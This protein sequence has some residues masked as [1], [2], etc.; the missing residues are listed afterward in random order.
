MANARA[1]AIG[2]NL[3]ALIIAELFDGPHRRDKV[4]LLASLN[5]DNPN[6]D[7]ERNEI[8]RALKSAYPVEG[9]NGN[10][11]IP[12]LRITFQELAN[13]QEGEFHQGIL[14]G[15]LQINLGNAK[16]R[17]ISRSR[18]IIIDTLIRV[19]PTNAFIVADDI[20]S[21]LA[22]L[23]AFNVLNPN[24]PDQRNAILAALKNAFPDEPAIQAMN[25][26]DFQHADINGRVEDAKRVAATRLR[27]VIGAALV[28]TIQGLDP[29]AP[30][31]AEKLALLNALNVVDPDAPA[32]RNLILTRL[33]AVYPPDNN[34]AIGNIT[35]NQLHALQP[36]DLQ[37]ADIDAHVTQAKTAAATKLRIVIGD[38]LVAT[39]QGLNP[40]TAPRAV[41]KMEFLTALNA[42][43]PNTEP[44][45]I[46]ILRRLKLVYALTDDP[47][48]A[49]GNMTGNQLNALQ[50]ND[51][52]GGDIDLTA[53]KREAATKLRS[54][55]GTNLVAT[56]RGL[57]LAAP[58]V[59]EKLALL[60]ALNVVAP[61]DGAARN[62]ILTQLKAVYPNDGN[63]TPLGI[64]GAQL[65]ALNANDLQGADINQQ[66]EDAKTAAATQLRGVIGAALLATIQ[67]LDPAAPPREAEKLALLNA[68]N[69]VD[70]NNPND[71]AARTEILARLQAVYP[72]DNNPAIGNMTGN[73]LRALQPN[74]LQG[75]DINAQVT[76]AKNAAEIKMG[77]RLRQLLA[78]P[79]FAT[80]IQNLNFTVNSEAKLTLLSKLN[81]DVTNAAVRGEILVALKAA[82]RDN[83]N[84]NTPIVALGGITSAQL[85]AMP[86]NALENAN[87]VDIDLT[88]A[89]AQAIAA[90]HLKRLIDRHLLTALQNLDFTVLGD[91]KR[92]LVASINVPHPNDDAERDA[93]LLALQN[94]YPDNND[95]ITRL[96][97]ITGHQLRTIPADG[98]RGAELNDAINA[99]KNEA[100]FQQFIN[101]ADV[102][103]MPH[104]GNLLSEP[105]VKALLITR[106]AAHPAP[107][108]LNNLLEAVNRANLTA[109]PFS[110]A[111]AI[112]NN[113]LTTANQPTVQ[114]ALARINGDST[115]AQQMLLGEA[116]FQQF[117]AR[118]DI[119]NLPSLEAMLKAPGVKDLLVTRFGADPA[120]RPPANIN[121]LVT[122]VSQASDANMVN[123]I[124]DHLPGNDGAAGV[125]RAAVGAAIG[126]TA[127]DCRGEARYQKL[128]T[129]NARLLNDMGRLQDFLTA[130]A[131]K[132]ALINHWKTEANQ[133]PTNLIALREALTHTN[134]ANA[135]I[136]AIDNAMFNATPPAVPGNVPGL[137]AALATVIHTPQAV[138]DL[139]RAAIAGHAELTERG[140]VDALERKLDDI[141]EF[142][143]CLSEIKPD[144]AASLAALR[145]SIIELHNNLGVNNDHAIYQTTNKLLKVICPNYPTDDLLV[146]QPF[147]TEVQTAFSAAIKETKSAY[148]DVRDSVNK[149]VA[150]KSS[151]DSYRLMAD[152][153]ADEAVRH[154]GSVSSFD[155][156]A[157]ERVLKSCATMQYALDLAEADLRATKSQL[158]HPTSGFFQTF[159]DIV[160]PG[161]TRKAIANIDSRLSEI[162]Q[163]RAAL[164]EARNTIKKA[165]KG[166]PK[167]NCFSNEYKVY[168]AGT[169]KEDILHEI[170]AHN[171]HAGA[172]PVHRLVAVA[173]GGEVKKSDPFD[174]A[175]RVNYTQLKLEDNSVAHVASMQGVM[176]DGV[177]QS[178]LL[179]TDDQIDN[180]KHAELVKYAVIEVENYL[181]G[182]PNKD[183]KM[184]LEDVHPKLAKAITTYCKLKCNAKGY[185]M[186]TPEE[187]GEKG[188]WEKRKDEKYEK[189]FADILTT[190]GD[191]IYRHTKG[192]LGFHHSIIDEARKETKT[193]TAHVP[194]PPSPRRRS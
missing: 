177:Y 169:S 75:A 86:A 2:A 50:P 14:G 16:D 99:A 92:T 185:S 43:D 124:A 94:A 65:Y 91:E 59:V 55:I 147:T 125:Y 176:E 45:R 134:D 188:F 173:G 115:I 156:R 153:Y 95:P 100:R 28:A 18:G 98:L 171:V 7:E 30:P 194:L 178:R 166:T 140:R 149:L 29:A 79:V 38:A 191:S 105:A 1:E 25:P 36:D 135:A 161:N 77:E 81:A 48:L 23:S 145:D 108:N 174:G 164:T 175:V 114:V 96:G 158:Q 70:P 42:V 151:I 180:M 89:K 21:R 165:Q 127:A 138:T 163:S 162:E 49:L 117:I 71:P 121:D 20:A 119:V 172:Y 192:T 27:S 170:D 106:F 31:V 128:L 132:T 44:A 22:V 137:N 146:A 143:T 40:A 41:E 97:G 60:T 67:G 82:Y 63:A 110:V 123:A 5:V 39:V 62:E 189:S 46:E 157:T 139:R 57:D 90:P 107:A 35:G 54:V 184:D 136:T 6:G 113:L 3:E 33:Q 66:V 109:D 52:R 12:H 141:R 84:P 142:E 80:A 26:A 64:T 111:N 154:S 190:Q 15:G 160:N 187:K 47:I 37:G 120:N 130:P 182:N 83:T 13:L 183:D 4:R 112:A 88:A 24:Q 116:R 56:V 104:L 144:D 93:I 150:E 10:N 131:V 167:V 53:A 118:P 85:Q 155:Q 159:S 126:V 103:A 179:Y 34:L 19:I 101:R 148:V 51:L 32:A 186:L 9:G 122:A 181:A 87:G 72:A 78:D 76:A 68:L 193:D 129:D 168:P 8:L 102:V 74:D 69:V 17:A 11:Q 133:P 152:R 73:Q 58:P 61:N